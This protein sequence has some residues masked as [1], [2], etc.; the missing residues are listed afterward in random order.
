MPM[1]GPTSP[2]LPPKKDTKQGLPSPAGRCANQTGL[3]FS[4]FAFS[5]NANIGYQVVGR[6]PALFCNC[7]ECA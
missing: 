2:A 7:L 6:N 5:E 1:S 4:L 3:L